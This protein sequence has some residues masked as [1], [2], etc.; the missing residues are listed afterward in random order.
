MYIVFG[1]PKPPLPPAIRCRL[2]AP[3]KNPLGRDVLERDLLWKSCRQS[4]NWLGYWSQARLSTAIRQPGGITSGLPVIRPVLFNGL[5]K[6]KREETQSI[7]AALDPAVRASND[8][9]TW[10]RPITAR[11]ATDF[12]IKE[13]GKSGSALFIFATLEVIVG[14]SLGNKSPHAPVIY[15]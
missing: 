15:S 7:R 9:R 10:R 2:T 11:H 13:N 1:I 3:S 4:W 14:C 8:R 12:T 6:S 5:Y